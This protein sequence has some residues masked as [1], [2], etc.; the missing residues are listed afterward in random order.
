MLPGPIA[1]APIS[2]I[3]QVFYQVK[4]SSEEYFFANKTPRF[5]LFEG[6]RRHTIFEFFSLD[7]V[8]RRLYGVPVYDTRTKT[9]PPH[10]IVPVVFAP[11]QVSSNFV[12]HDFGYLELL[13]L[14]TCGNLSHTTYRPRPVL[15]G[16]LGAITKTTNAPMLGQKECSG[17][18][19]ERKEE[20]VWPKKRPFKT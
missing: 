18:T 7:L 8:N 10:R 4:S 16:A 3:A 2:G 1:Q 11:I 13:G 14:H 20:N 5:H 12:S 15:P 9:T 6:A 19:P 17:H